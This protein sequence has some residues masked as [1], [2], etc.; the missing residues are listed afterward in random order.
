MP[1]FP[2]VPDLEGVPAV[3]RNA[4]A[5]FVAAITDTTLTVSSVESGII[6]AGQ[7]ITAPGVATGT[8]ILQAITGIGGVGTY[9][10]NIAQSLASQAMGVLGNLGL[11]TSA[12]AQNDGLGANQAQPTGPVWGLFDSSGNAVITPTS[13][14]GVDFHSEARVPSYP[15]ELGSF[16]SYNK[17]NAPYEARPT[18]TIGGTIAERTSF[19]TTC[20]NL[21][22]DVNLYVWTT[23][24]FSYP[25]VNFVDY[26]Y[27]RTGERG[28]Q[29]IT[30][31]AHLQEIRPAP[32]PSF[33]NTAD[34]SGQAQTQNGA[35]QPQTPTAGQTAQSQGALANSQGVQ[36]ELLGGPGS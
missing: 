25:N 28:V 19:L 14:L 34:P 10:V 2:Q 32:A 17:V 29:L 15:I 13:W 27:S 21:K 30:V 18:M 20:K 33:S 26:S 35:V 1:Q 12:P 8:Q 6:T 4:G 36:P 11:P 22:E 5:S 24:E 7:M 23:P 3:F 9:A 31:E 16:G